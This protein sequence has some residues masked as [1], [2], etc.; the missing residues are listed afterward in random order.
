MTSHIFILKQDHYKNKFSGC[1]FHPID[2]IFFP[3][4]TSDPLR[5]LMVPSTDQLLFRSALA[6]ILICLYHLCA[7]TCSFPRGAR[8]LI[9]AQLSLTGLGSWPAAAE[10]EVA[11]ALNLTAS[12]S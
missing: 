3:S 4:T 12:F 7:P 8:N 6:V 5:T 1:K 10:V 9:L 11:S 2:F